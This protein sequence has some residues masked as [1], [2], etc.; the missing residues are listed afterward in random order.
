M[1]GSI[2]FFKITR[3]QF[4]RETSAAKNR[5]LRKRFEITE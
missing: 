1:K 3:T 5:L 4:F 2:E